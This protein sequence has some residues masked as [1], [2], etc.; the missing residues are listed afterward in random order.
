ML[1]TRVKR[2]AN[3]RNSISNDGGHFLLGNHAYF[4]LGRTQSVSGM[5]VIEHQG[6]PNGLILQQ[7]W[8][9]RRP[10]F[11]SKKAS[12]KYRCSLDFYIYHHVLFVAFNA[13][14]IWD[15]KLER[16]QTTRDSTVVLNWI[17]QVR[18][19]SAISFFE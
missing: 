13:I 4:L 18:G 12:K 16:R 19:R 17:L 3:S 14:I 9:S 6:N 10:F 7:S 2:W 5:T 11:K 8:N 15:A 1:I